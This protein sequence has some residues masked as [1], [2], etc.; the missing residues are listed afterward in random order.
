[1]GLAGLLRNPADGQGCSRWNSRFTPRDQCS[2]ADTRAHI[3]Q[4]NSQREA[5]QR[6]SR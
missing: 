1:M 6:A 4:G 5:K 2:L 3:G